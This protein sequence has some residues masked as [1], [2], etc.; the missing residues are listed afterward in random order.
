MFH[1]HQDTGGSG[2]DISTVGFFAAWMLGSIFVAY[3][4]MKYSQ[5]K[6]EARE[7]AE[8]RR[9]KQQVQVKSKGASA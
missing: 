5:M 1:A 9:Q 2:V 3:Y 8:K 6:R 4:A 7:A